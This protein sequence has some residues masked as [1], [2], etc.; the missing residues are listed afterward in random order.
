MFTTPIQ[1]DL[2][3]TDRDAHLQRLGAFE[4]V[5]D[6][7]IIG[8]G[9]TGAAIALDA[10][11][12]GLSFCLFERHAFASGTSSRSTKLIHGGVRYLRQGN[13]K[14]VREALAEREALTKLAP[15]F[16]KPLPFVVPCYRWWE[17][18]YYGLGLKA[19][20]WLAGETSY[21][22]SRKLGRA[23]VIERLPTLRQDGL[24][25]GVLYYDGQFHDR[26]LAE[27]V[28]KTAARVAGDAGVL[29]AGTEVVGIEEDGVVVET[30]GRRLRARAK[31]VINAAGPYCD[32]VRQL[33]DR[34]TPPIIRPSRGT[35]LLLDA[36]F[37]PDE[38]AVMVPKT[39]D[40]RLIFITPWNGQTLIGTTDF[41]T[42]E[43]CDD[44]QAT[45]GEIDYLLDLAG[46][47]LAVL[48]TRSDIRS[49][50]AGIRPLVVAGTS[51]TAK[52]SREHTILRGP[53]SL[54]TI[55]GGKWTTFRRMAH[56]VLE[57]ALAG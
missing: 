4:T 52:L 54:L 31:Q 11:E 18:S 13:L 48:P 38:T 44:P 37:L 14:L 32:A 51:S 7:A 9:A 24:R 1:R 8:G 39:P 56:D 27:A 28:L 20:D 55:T 10:A 25:G 29:L 36:S 5:F 42:D 43:L 35:H 47:Y 12:R 41:A 33:V 57:Q 26:E 2:P 15:D 30:G 34:A 45:H 53:G 22:R 40:G 50:F 17:C 46:Q 6:L 49:T 3:P 21:P 23:A 16:V 19:Y